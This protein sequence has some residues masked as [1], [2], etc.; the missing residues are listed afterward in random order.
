MYHFLTFVGKGSS[1]FPIVPGGPS[2]SP[3]LMAVWQ[4]KKHGVLSRRG[5]GRG[6]LAWG[7]T[8]CLMACQCVCVCVRTAAKEHLFWK[9][10]FPSAQD[11]STSVYQV[12]T[13]PRNYLI[14]TSH[15]ALV[16]FPTVT[17]LQQLLSFH[18]SDPRLAMP[19]TCHSFVSP[20]YTSSN[21]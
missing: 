18:S 13:K 3:V 12:F 11:R 21:G 10:I 16:R 15:Q 9:Q 20:Q 17:G 7:H 8:I 14:R 4:Q 2:C 1:W 5:L 6:L 19:R